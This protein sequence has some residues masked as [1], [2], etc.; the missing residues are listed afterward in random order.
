MTVDSGDLERDDQTTNPVAEAAQ[1][2]A[3]REL[4]EVRG[5]RRKAEERERQLEERQ[6]RLNEGQARTQWARWVERRS[7]VFGGVASAVAFAVLAWL[8]LEIG[9]GLDV[10]YRTRLIVCLGLSAGAF[11]LLVAS[12][13]GPTLMEA[14]RQQREAERD[15]RDEAAAAAD[16]LDDANDLV[17][18][19]KANRKQMTAYD[20]LAQ[21]QAKTAFRNSQIAMTAGLL[22][23]L[24]GAVIAISTPT[25]TSKIA[26]T[27]L[28]AIGGAVAGF[29]AK[30]FLGT[31]FRAVQQLNFYFQQPLINSYVLTAQRLIRDLS[32]AQRDPALA[33][34]IGRITDALIRPS[35]V[36][37]R[38]SAL[39]GKERSDASDADADPSSA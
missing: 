11:L 14:R 26:A 25:L 12:G 20:V 28:T 9:G 27:T 32:S 24:V 16:E 6:A 34:V 2:S 22:V 7:Y 4:V 38:G 23:L 5:D 10:P 13:V 21:A 29:I 37:T 35:D 18:L 31:Y 3:R 39:S 36:T 15:A 19:I 1:E 30:T 8:S 17:A 33:K